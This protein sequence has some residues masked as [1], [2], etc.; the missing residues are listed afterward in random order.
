VTPATADSRAALA[1][2]VAREFGR[3]RCQVSGCSMM[4]AL[5]PGDLVLVERTDIGD[6]E[7]GDIVMIA[8]RGR[9]IVHRVVAN[10]SSYSGPS[11]VTQGDTSPAA[12]PPVAQEDFVGIV[13]GIVRNGR[14][15]VPARERGLIGRVVAATVERSG[16]VSRVLQWGY[17]KYAADTGAN[18][19][20]GD[21]A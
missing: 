17:A 19:F 4:P 3:V 2:E 5:W 15:L 18:E 14:E 7:L 13:T 21:A 10:G 16:F 11:L 8:S 12:D 6:V 1:I 20:A 9:L